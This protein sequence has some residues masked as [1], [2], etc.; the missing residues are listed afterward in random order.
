MAKRLP[1]PCLG[2]GEPTTGA[3]GRCD[4]CRRVYRRPGDRRQAAR[5]ARRGDTARARGYDTA[6]DNLSRRARELQ[7][8]CTDCGSTT[9]LQVDHSPAAW[10]K[11]ALG[12]SLTL[13][14]VAVV[15]GPCNRARGR[16]RGLTGTRGGIPSR[17][18]PDSGRVSKG[19]S[20][21]SD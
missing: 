18:T 8:W 10:R 20:Y 3:R 14:D 11:R 21:S 17:G 16:A 13:S 19:G 6:W 7:P 5:R 4:E 2:C 15:C 12:R 9:D 1:V